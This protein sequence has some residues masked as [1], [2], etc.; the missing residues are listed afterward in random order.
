MAHFPETT[1]I[2]WVD[3]LAENDYV[4]I[5]N[6]IT[7]EEYGLYRKFLT[8]KLNANNFSRAGIGL[9]KEVSSSIRGDFIYWL[10]QQRDT[11]LVHFFS[12]ADEMV[13]HFNRLCYLS[14]GGYEFHLAY[15]PAGSFYKKHIDQFRGRGNRLITLIIYLNEN[16]TPANGGQLRIFC[17]GEKKVIDPV[18]RR[19]VLFRSE[20]L[21]HEVL[22]TQVPRYSLTGWLLYQPAGLGQLLG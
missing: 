21:P 12:L 13:S 14:L 19:C 7:M 4:V 8:T 15:Y 1:W 3:Q 6:F 5:D 20:V 2:E 11:E 10:D 16:W 18:A 22:L 17:N 9:E